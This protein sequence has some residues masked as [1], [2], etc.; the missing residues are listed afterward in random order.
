MWT[1][2]FIASSKGNTLCSFVYECLC[3][4]WDKYESAIDYLFLDSIISIGYEEIMSIT[5]EINA[6]PENNAKV[7]EVMY[8][9]E[10]LEGENTIKEKLNASIINKL[11]YKMVRG[12]KQIK[13]MENVLSSYN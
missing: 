7:F 13:L 4:Y 1:T 6:V 2:F 12:E 5:R 9:F 10:K 3:K 11:T 8:L